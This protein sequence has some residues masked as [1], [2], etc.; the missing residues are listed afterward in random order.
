MSRDI[1][2]YIAIEGTIGA[3]KTSLATMLSEELNSRLILE[4]FEENDFLPKFYKD[5][6]KYAFP[7]EL[8]FLASRFQ[9][10]K[11]ELSVTDIF[12]NVIISDYFISKSLIFSKATLQEDEFNLYSKL[13]NIINLSL[14]WPDMIVY[15]YASVNR[16]KSNIILRGR[17]YEQNIE[18]SY[19]QRIQEG[20][21]EYL[22]KINDMRILIIDTNKLDFVNR[23]EHYEWLKN[24]IF[25]P[26]EMGIHRIVYENS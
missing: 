4:Q 9:Q 25:Q 17:T 10:L 26:Y 23:A 16:L 20:Y 13:F 24:V 5:P 15:L 19:L 21:F 7:L 1:Y 2:N 11:T 6:E 12:R 8:S 14:P 22:S 18:N 3:G